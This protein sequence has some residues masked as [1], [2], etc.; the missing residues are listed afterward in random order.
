LKFVDEPT[1]LRFFMG[2][3]APTSDWPARLVKQFKKDFGDSL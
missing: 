3:L 2:R 1:V